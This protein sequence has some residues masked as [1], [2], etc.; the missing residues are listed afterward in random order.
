MSPMRRQLLYM[1]P[2]SI[3]GRLMTYGTKLATLLLL[4]D[5]GGLGVAGQGAHAL[6]CAS[7]G[8]PLHVMKMLRS[9]A[10]RDHPVVTA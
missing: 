9:E 7:C 5:A 2:W 3:E 4:R 10:V 8:A 1:R 6:S